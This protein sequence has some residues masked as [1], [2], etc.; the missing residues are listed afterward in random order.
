MQFCQDKA[1]EAWLVCGLLAVEEEV[2]EGLTS[3]WMAA[4]RAAKWTGLVR[5]SAKPASLLRATSSS[6]P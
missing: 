6:I 3:W 4:E 5:W 2:E 1:V